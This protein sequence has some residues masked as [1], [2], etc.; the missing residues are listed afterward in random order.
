MPELPA[1]TG[2]SQADHRQIAAI[3]PK[4]VLSAG[5]LGLS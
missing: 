2:F 5:M 3:R 1:F 4:T